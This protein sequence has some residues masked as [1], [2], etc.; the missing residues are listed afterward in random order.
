MPRQIDELMN[1]ENNL[2]FV[3]DRPIL[4]AN[5][6]DTV[7]IGTLVDVIGYLNHHL[8]SRRIPFYNE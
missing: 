3:F 2:T 7:D 6:A 5:L 1:F 8:K 4:K